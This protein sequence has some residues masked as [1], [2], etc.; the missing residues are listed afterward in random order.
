MRALM[1]K[2]KSGAKSKRSRRRSG[3]PTILGR[4]RR[5][6]TTQTAVNTEGVYALLR[7]RRQRP[8]LEHG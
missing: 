6:E 1:A 2:S 4:E 7:R 3:R 5:G 8:V